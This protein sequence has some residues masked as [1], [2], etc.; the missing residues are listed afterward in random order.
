[1]ACDILYAINV[2]N[3]AIQKMIRKVN[4][5]DI[6]NGRLYDANDMVKL[7]VDDCEGCHACCC[8]TG[9]TLSLD[10]YDIY[11]LE[12]GL[13]TDFKGLLANHLELR[14]A[15]GVIMPFL[16]MDN[17]LTIKSG[18]ISVTEK[19]ACTFLNSEG[20]CSIHEWRPSIC[21]LFPLGRIYE[22]EGHRYLLMENECHKERK[23]KVK[24]RKWL[25]TPDFAKY[26]KYIDDWHAF[27]STVTDHLSEISPENLKSWNT[28]MLQRFYFTDYDI[29][30][31]FFSQFYE[32]LNHGD[33]V[34]GSFSVFLCK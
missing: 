32:R 24:I 26:E 3:G 5:E 1:M 34:C 6:S 30:V 15:D 20:R 16:R 25:E 17:E 14:V 12:A 2:S 10:P 8:A 33:G 28:V 22:G 23:A 31:E 4:L 11:R 7:A 18:E 21:R 13:K 19:E 27:I 29:S 9:D